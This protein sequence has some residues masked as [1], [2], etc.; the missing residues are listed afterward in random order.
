[1]SLQ[2]SGPSLQIVNV[3]PDDRSKA[4]VC[5]RSL[6]GVAGSIP[7]RAWMSPSCKCCVLSD[8]SLS[9]VQRSPTD[10]GESNRMWAGTPQL[11]EAKAHEGCRAVY[12][13]A[14]FCVLL[15]N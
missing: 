12:R 10:C 11:E 13:K 14:R 6:A 3:R 7:A 5:S 2:E 4:R 8:R 1:M 15:L 9:L